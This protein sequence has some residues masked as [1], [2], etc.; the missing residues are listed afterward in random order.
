[1]QPASDQ[2]GDESAKPR[3]YFATTQWPAVLHA[4]RSDSSSARE[5]LAQL[6]QSYWY[7]LYAYARAEINRLMR[8]I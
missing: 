3:D 1:M 7:P 2:P 8:K 4:G 5:A 6:C